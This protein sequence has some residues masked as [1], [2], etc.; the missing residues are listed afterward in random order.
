ME[1][2]SYLYYQLYYLDGSTVY[3]YYDNVWP[4]PGITDSNVGIPG[5]FVMRADFADTGYY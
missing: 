5:V 3:A 2:Y 4:V 1:T